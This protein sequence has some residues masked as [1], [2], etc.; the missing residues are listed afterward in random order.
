[1]AKQKKKTIGIKTTRYFTKTCSQCK[2]EYPNWFTN[3]PKC[4]AAWDFGEAEK[5]LDQEDKSKKNI[6]IVVKITEE[7][8][9]R[10]LQLVQLIFSA[11]HG[12]SWYQMKMENKQDYFIAEIADV[13][14]GITIIYYI[15]VYLENGNIIIENNEGNYFFY[16]VGMPIEYKE[17]EEQ[18]KPPNNVS[19]ETYDEDI[20]SDSKFKYQNS[21]QELIQ[22]NEYFIPSNKDLD[23]NVLKVQSENVIPPAKIQPP[24]DP[25]DYHFEKNVTIFGVPQ[26]EIDPD[27]KVCPYCNS[28]IKKMWS[29][30]PICG[31][32]L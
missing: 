16:K 3:C 14:T 12:K 1:M 18:V 21:Q 26:V 13:P 17:Q 2:F 20:L 10:S 9:D 27:L 5:V 23:R 8:F 15:R 25:E 19:Y 31:K 6:K 22:G 11:D 29:I 24:S 4:G 32:N 28:K 30:C 7:D